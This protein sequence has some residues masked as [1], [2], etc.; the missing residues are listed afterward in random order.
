MDGILTVVYY[1]LFIITSSFLLLLSKVVKTTNFF[2]YL[3]IFVTIFY[4]GFRFN[5][6][7]DFPT[8]YA[9]STGWLDYSRLEPI[10][11]VI[12]E[13]SVYLNTPAIFFFITST[14]YILCVSLFCRKMSDNKE[15]SFFLFLVLPLSFLTSLGYVRQFM[16]IGFF[17]AAL[18]LYIDG[19]TKFSFLFMIF[20]ILCHATAIFAIP[21]IF[22]FKILSRRKIPFL[23]SIVLMVLAYTSSKLIYEFAYLAGDYQHYITGTNVI[24]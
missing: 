20:S 23:L 19:K 1:S 2:F 8:Y 14:L 17:I 12:M 11:R 9:M 15:L 4:S 18:S 24:E 3:A 22:L 7:N 21:C 13:L 5:A 10:P 6:G 16:S